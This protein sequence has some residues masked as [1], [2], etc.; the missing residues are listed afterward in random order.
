LQGERSWFLAQQAGIHAVICK[1]IDE[2]ISAKDEL[3]IIK[4]ELNSYVI[5]I[6]SDT[7]DPIAL[8]EQLKHEIETAGSQYQYAKDNKTNQGTIS[9]QLNLLKLSQEVKAL[10]SEYKLSPTH[11]RFL[12]QLPN[13]EQLNIA[14]HIISHKMSASQ[15]WKLTKE[16]I[17]AGRYNKTS[18]DTNILRLEKQVS[19]SIGFPVKIKH[20]KKG[21]G[22]II[23]EYFDLDGAQTIFT[24]LG[25]K[26]E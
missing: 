5:K 15:S 26:G 16:F 10:I 8:T 25:Y 18:Y 14:R 3:T 9:H 2:P 4:N 17:T 13:T 7:L 11:A 1:V 21:S 20:K 6:A 22:K 24:K 19:E 12:H 23:I